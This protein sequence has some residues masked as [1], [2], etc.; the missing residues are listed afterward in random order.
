MTTTGTPP[1]PERRRASVAG[2]ER[3]SDSRAAILEA[4][5]AVLLAEG[6]EGMSIRRVTDRCG[7]TAPTIYHH[8]GDKAGLVRA[9]LEARFREILDVMEAIPRDGDAAVYLR[10]SARAFVRFALEN[11][12]Y[13]RLLTMPGL[14]P[15]SV[16]SA[17]S[18]RALVKR[19][20]EQLAREGTLAT[21][22]IEA[23][24][25]TTWAMIHGLISLRL[26]HA[27]HRFSDRM[28]ELAFD[29]M[30]GGLLRREPRARERNVE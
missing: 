24:F 22:D 20:L 12:S 29:V 11:P 26:L 21:R 8:F 16:P 3:A 4:T 9:L 10:E 17:E 1:A 30:E 27:D 15:Q 13:Y 7:Y 28:I 2:G 18:S 5:E 25:E 23:A 14:D 6:V 19:A